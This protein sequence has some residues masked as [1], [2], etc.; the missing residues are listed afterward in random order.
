MK[1]INFVGS[2][3]DV[4]KEINEWLILRPSY[5]IVHQSH[6]TY[7]TEENLSTVNKLIVGIFY[8]SK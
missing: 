7:T 6:V 8:N 4:E 3:A 2:A 1:Y 5:T